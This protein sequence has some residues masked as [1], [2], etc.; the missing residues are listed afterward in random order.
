[1]DW[2]TKYTPAQVKARHSQSRPRKF[3]AALRIEL[4]TE[5]NYSLALLTM[6]D[7]A[8]LIDDSSSMEFEEDHK[9]IT[10]LE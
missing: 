2:I 6:Y 7:L 9:R 3:I 1:M 4:P 8:V 5:A 10:I